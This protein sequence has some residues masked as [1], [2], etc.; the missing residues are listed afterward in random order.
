MVREAVAHLAQVIRGVDVSG[1]ALEEGG[2]GGPIALQTQL[3]QRRL[4][5]QVGR[6][7]QARVLLGDYEQHVAVLVHRVTRWPPQMMECAL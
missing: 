2:D 5:D 1:G 4:A 6:I 3:V 7:T